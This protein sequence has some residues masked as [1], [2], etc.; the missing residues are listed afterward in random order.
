MR[1]DQETES[2]IKLILH[3]HFPLY[4]CEP[5]SLKFLPFLLCLQGCN[6]YGPVWVSA[7]P[8][9]KGGGVGNVCLL[10]IS[11]LGEGEGTRFAEGLGLMLSK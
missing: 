11:A 1:E 5:A 10:H 9:T 2:N 8:A 3:V 7:N 4:P 6:P